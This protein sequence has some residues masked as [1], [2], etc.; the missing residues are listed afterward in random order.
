MSDS[1]SMPELM[2]PIRRDVSGFEQLPMQQAGND[3]VPLGGQSMIVAG[4]REITAKK[5]A[6][7]RDMR[8]ILN[9]L[10]VYCNS[11]G[12]TYVY[13][14]EVND[15]R[16]NRRVTIEGGT[17]KL[18]N[19]LVQ[20]YGNCSVDLDVQE[21]KTHW[22]FKAFF[23]DYER[24]TCVSRLFQQRKGQDTGMK[25][26]DRQSDMVFQIGQSKAIRNVV[27]NALASLANR[28][29]EDSKAGLIERFQAEEGR[30]RALNFVEKVRAHYN[31]DITRME[32]VAGR[33]A[34]DWT[35]RDL[36]QIWTQCRAIVDGMASAADVFPSLEDAG[37]LL[38]EK[39]KE[40]DAGKKR[41]STDGN[42]A[43]QDEEKPKPQQRKAAA[44]KEDPKPKEKAEEPAPAEE[45]KPDVKQ[46]A[47]KPAAKDEA[48]ESDDLAIPAFLKREKAPAE[49]TE[50]QGEGESGEEERDAALDEA[51]T[52][53]EDIFA[54]IVACESAAQVHDVL[55][56]YA[57]A[58]DQ[59]LSRK[60]RDDIE[61]RAQSF[62]KSIEQKPAKAPSKASTPPADSAGS[63][64]I[65]FFGGDS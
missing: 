65:D 64:D 58:M 30:Q 21:T 37:A 8:R 12:D 18:A 42:T 62:I 59:R 28:A 20:L 13:S 55:E 51:Q 25:D 49:P 57:D 1:S 48:Q 35:A 53:A 26:A 44:K 19:D 31:V 10:R 24:G 46:A 32:A 38:E 6:V 60:Q 7:A 16:N 22:I 52:L 50:A 5:V 61:A 4:P 40:R 39:E 3:A 29:V 9:E 14:W 34:K 36:A 41:A 47:T 43:A 23:I 45:S 27:L 11:F 15:R 56:G 2:E 33:K 54:E 17:I 63:D